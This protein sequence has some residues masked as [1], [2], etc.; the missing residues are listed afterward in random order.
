MKRCPLITRVAMTKQER[1]G[2]T[3]TS[4]QPPRHQPPPAS[5]KSVLQTNQR[6]CHWVTPQ[7]QDILRGKPPAINNILRRWE[8]CHFL[9]S[10]QVPILENWWLDPL[11]KRKIRTFF[12]EKYSARHHRLEQLEF[13]ILKP[14]ERRNIVMFIMAKKKE[15][16]K[17]TRNGQRETVWWS[18]RISWLGHQKSRKLRL[19]N[20][21]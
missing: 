3:K 2:T 1:N 14:N 17:Y 15:E 5:K 11:I 6:I 8:N 13:S 9:G 21:S 10:G 18:L 19:W 12:D 7:C 4:S 16:T 20:F